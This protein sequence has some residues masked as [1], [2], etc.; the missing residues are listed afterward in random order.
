[1]IDTPE[2]KDASKWGVEFA[3][4]SKIRDLIKL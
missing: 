3:Q 2:Y 1:V 4:L